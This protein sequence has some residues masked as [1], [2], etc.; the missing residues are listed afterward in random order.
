MDK[1]KS[2]YI[3]SMYKRVIV[4]ST[5]TP[6]PDFELALVELRNNDILDRLNEKDK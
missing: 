4:R 2:K 6:N 5:L 1:D 3:H